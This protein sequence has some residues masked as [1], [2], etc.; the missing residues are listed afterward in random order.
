[1]GDWEGRGVGDS[2][3]RGVG[4]S[5]G[6]GVGVADGTEGKAEEKKTCYYAA[7]VNIFVWTKE[8]VLLSGDGVFKCVNIYVY[9]PQA[10]TGYTCPMAFVV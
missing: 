1:M 7:I 2:E 3:G 6:A 10:F 9:S 5:E 8:H 4:D